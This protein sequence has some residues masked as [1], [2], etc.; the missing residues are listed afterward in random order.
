VHSTKRS[1]MKESSGTVRT[2]AIENLAPDILSE[3][4][5]AMVDAFEGF[6][7]ICSQDFHIEFMNQRF[8]DHHKGDK[9][10]QLCYQALHNLSEVCPWC[11]NDRVLSGES[12]RWELKSPIDGRWRRAVNVPILHKDGTLS[13]LAMITD[14]TDAKIQSLAL[15]EG[16]ARFR[17]LADNL[18]LT[19]YEADLRG[20]FQFVN[21]T[22]LTWFGYSAEDVA[23][24]I[25]IVQ[26]VIEK[27]R[28][29]AMDT[30]RQLLAG[31]KPVPHEYT[32]LRKDGT[33]FPVLIVTRPI[34]GKDGRPTGIRGIVMDITE[35][36]QIETALQNAQ[37]LESVGVLAG[38]IAHDFNNLLS[39]IFGYLYLARAKVTD[40]DAK[41]NI[42]QAISVFSRAKALTQ[43]LL[44]FAKGGFP[45]K[46]T[47]SLS[48]VLT[49]AVRF[50]LSGSNIKAAFDVADG[51][52]PCDADAHQIGQVIDNIVINAREA[53]PLGGTIAIIARNIP[54]SDPHPAPLAARPY[55]KIEIR[56]SGIG[57]PA[58]IL[59][60]VFDPFFTTKQHGSGLGLATAYSI[61]KKHEGHIFA[62]SDRSNGSTFTVYLPAASSDAPISN[63]VAHKPVRAKSPGAV[64]VMDDEEFIR[65]LYG[66]AI[67]EMGFT[68]ALA[69]DGFQAIELFKKAF[70]QGKP[71]D[72]VILDLTIP[73][74]M[75]GMQ[76]IA[77]IKK[78]CPSA[79]A[80]ASSGYSDDPVMANPD[81]FGFKGKLVKPFL[82]DDLNAIIHDL[83]SSPSRD[84]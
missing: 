25:N 79:V 19:V 13:K 17:E 81:K 38:G 24:G 62:E 42:D 20:N 8:I 64:L 57:I 83:F 7:Y 72:L 26:T 51:L 32:G 43:Q 78:I 23:A 11:V 4:Y 18:P 67:R 6:I 74:G 3:R 75:G 71:F 16:E 63:P 41:E 73:G 45:L 46:K 44:T 84:R 22:G 48:A 10:G 82:V 12:V 76:A 35:R 14:I 29:R 30:V 52:W 61:V 56:D 40:E 53:M 28:Q 70:D 65:V 21:A 77:E 5:R 36:K 54:A 15:Q 69:G 55:V 68:V 80:I 31:N 27:D 33:M 9:T 37:K 1:D 2:G 34:A 47:I 66:K 50:A 58:D 59:G 60:R 39:G 49:E